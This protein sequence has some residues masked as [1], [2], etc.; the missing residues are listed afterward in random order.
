MDLAHH[1]ICLCLFLYKGLD[2]QKLLLAARL[3]AT[4]IVEGEFWVALEAKFV[5]NI[6]NT[7]L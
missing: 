3:K 5:P 2:V 6:V 1:I 7:S 4:G